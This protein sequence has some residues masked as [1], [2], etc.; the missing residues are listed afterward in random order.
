MV[1]YTPLPGGGQAAGGVFAQVSLSALPGNYGR[2]GLLV[3]SSVIRAIVVMAAVDVAVLR[4]AAVVSVGKT[5]TGC[6]QCDYHRKNYHF[7][8][9]LHYSCPLPL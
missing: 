5:G 6:R 9:N 2:A 1:N 7:H 8:T 3:M 4:W